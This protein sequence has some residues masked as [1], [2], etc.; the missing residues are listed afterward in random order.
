L[1]SSRHELRMDWLRIRAATPLSFEL[2]ALPLRALYQGIT[3]RPPAGHRKAVTRS[4]PDVDSGASSAFWCFQ[5]LERAVPVYSC[6]FLTAAPAAAALRFLSTPPNHITGTSS[7][8]PSFAI[9]LSHFCPL[10]PSFKLSRPS[11]SAQEPSLLSSTERFVHRASPSI[12]PAV[13][14]DHHNGANIVRLLLFQ[15]CKRNDSSAILL[16]VQNIPRIETPR[17][18]VKTETYFKRQR[19]RPFPLSNERRMEVQ[20]RSPKTPVLPC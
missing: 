20:A 18:I 6:S 14:L 7:T 2:R 10:P 5:V 4:W 8:A 3:L 1:K 15:T 11:R 9:R 13:G 17:S 16:S 19:C 12:S